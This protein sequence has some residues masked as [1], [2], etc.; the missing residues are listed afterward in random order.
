MLLAKHM[1]Q[2]ID[3]YSGGM[4]SFDEGLYA[5]EDSLLADAIWRNACQM[6]EAAQP[7][8]LLAMVT[9]ARRQLA[10]MHQN[11]RLTHIL[12]RGAISWVQ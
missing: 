2:Y 11:T 3:Y 6:N 5:Q 4:V 8:D 10:H 7:T 9:F 12:E 1:K